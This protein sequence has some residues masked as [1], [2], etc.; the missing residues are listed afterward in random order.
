MAVSKQKKEEILQEL[1]D[2]I[3]RLKTAVFIDFS[4]I[5][6]A[7]L[8]KIRNELRAAE[9]DLQVAKKTLLNLA[10]KKHKVDLNV[11]ELQGQV[12]AIFGYK[13]ETAPARILYKFTK[14]VEKL[15][16][17]AGLLGKEFLSVERVEALAKLPSRKELL[18]QMVGSMQAPVSGFV[19]V[20]AGNIRGLVQVL[21]AISQ[22]QRN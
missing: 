14:E 8:N 22:S 17:L 20:L 18:G 4:G 7:A 11:R 12:A 19:N 3:S 15:K 6:V 16:I 2:K 5:D 21:G 13:D 10:L 9:A 1:E